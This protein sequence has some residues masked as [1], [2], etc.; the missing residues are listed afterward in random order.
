MQNQ[1]EPSKATLNQ[2][3]A[4]GQG[5]FYALTG[6]WSLVDIHSF[7][8]VTGP[9][10][11]RW[12]VKTVGTVVTA[13]GG[14][15]MFAAKRKN[16]SPE[17]SLLGVSSALGLAAIDVIY[18]SKKRISPIYLLDALAEV[19]IA[20]CWAAALNSEKKGADE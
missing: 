1:A 15:L 19:A 12:L 8:K 3:T 4:L 7:E 9:K 17:I 13:I 11:D 20:G 18:V 16:I 6:I 10:T 2:Q 5:V 14:T